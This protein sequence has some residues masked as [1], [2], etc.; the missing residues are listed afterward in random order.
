MAAPADAP[1]YCVRHP[2]RETLVACGRCERPFCTECLIHTPA[3][4]RC[5]ECAGVRRDYA[6]RAATARFAQAFGVVA[7]GAAI[8]SLAGLFGLLIAGFAG[9]IAGQLL[10]PSVNRRTRPWIYLPIAATLAGGTLTGWTV[11]VVIRILG[12]TAR[13]PGVV[14][15]VWS[16]PLALLFSPSFWL[17]VAIVA[18]AAYLRM[19]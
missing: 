6:Q 13:R 19:R 16:V 8:G 9:S 15:D 12:S 18:I 4:Q 11:L 7:L 5:Y 17:F 1:R 10:S 3:G 14:L 2:S